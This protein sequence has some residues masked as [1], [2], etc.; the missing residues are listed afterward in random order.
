MQ[1]TTNAVLSWLVS[2]GIARHRIV[3]TDH[4]GWLAFDATV[5]EAE[6][7][8]H[9]KYHEFEHSSMS[10]RS[11]GTDAYHVPE[12]LARHIDYITPGVKL[13]AMKKRTLSSDR[14]VSPGITAPTISRPTIT[15]SDDKNASSLA[16]CHEVLTP[17]CIRAL[18][19][20]SIPNVD[21]KPSPDNSLGIY[22][23][24]DVYYQQDL[25]DFFSEYAPSIGFK[26]PNGTHPVLKGIDGGGI[27]TP[28]NSS[29][30]DTLYNIL[31]DLPRNI[32]VEI[33]GVFAHQESELDFGIAYPIIYPQTITLYQV[34]DPLESTP[35]QSG[36]YEDF[37]DAIDGVSAKSLQYKQHLTRCSHT[38]RT[39]TRIRVA[40]IPPT[41]GISLTIWLQTTLLAIQ[42]RFNVE[43]T[44]RLV[45]SRSRM[46][47]TSTDIQQCM[48]KECVTS[49]RVPN[50]TG[51]LLTSVKIHEA[52][53]SRP[54][55]SLCCRRSGP[56]VEQRYMHWHK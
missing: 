17:A 19:N 24:A 6:S 25:N 36:G 32:S 22:E 10:K 55:F 40:T 11:I 39:R 21:R 56:R 44:S 5:E 28:W 1:E 38:A 14:P 47:E 30:N 16:Q 18:Y 49:R 29:L 41:M 37:L 20:I 9:A 50:F 23:A 13:S 8:F 27:G 53:S 26:I 48:W 15:F 54:H 7:L 2:A 34:L 35:F 45:W 42:V 4:K 12:R 33:T 31:P 43:F 52:Q 3:H 51:S 46:Q